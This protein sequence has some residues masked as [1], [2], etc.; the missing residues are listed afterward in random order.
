MYISLRLD[1][2]K[3]L[4]PGKILA[5]MEEKGDAANTIM[6]AGS[7]VAYT[8]VLYMPSF[9]MRHLRTAFTSSD[10]SPVEILKNMGGEHNWSSEMMDLLSDI[11]KCRRTGMEGELY[12]VGKAYELMAALIAMGTSRLPKKARIMSISCE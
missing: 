5:F 9:Y 8:E 1:Y 4:P 7:H 11:Q 2:A 10:A 3:H 12:Y 6:R